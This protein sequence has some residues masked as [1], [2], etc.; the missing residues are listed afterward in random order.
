LIAIGGSY[1]LVAIEVGEVPHAQV[2]VANHSV[3]S[4]RKL[5]EELL[6]IVEWTRLIHGL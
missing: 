3:R 6:Q 4:V 1:K 5:C 2:I